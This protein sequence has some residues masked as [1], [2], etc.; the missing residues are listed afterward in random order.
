MLTKTFAITEGLHAGGSEVPAASSEVV[1]LERGLIF[2]AAD[3]RE[4]LA[5]LAVA[6]N[7]WRVNDF[8]AT[9]LREHDALGRCPVHSSPP[10]A[11]KPCSSASS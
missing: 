4:R 5:L 9:G 8:G 2:G 7:Q 6:I 3:V 1:K 10:S 11:S